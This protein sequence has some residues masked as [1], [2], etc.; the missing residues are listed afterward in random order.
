MEGLSK[1][2]QFLLKRLLEQVKGL[3]DLIT[4][5][6]S[7][8]QNVTQGADYQGEQDPSDEEA[9]MEPEE[10]ESAVEASIGA[11]ALRQITLIHNSI[12]KVE[13]RQMIANP[14]VQRLIKTAGEIEAQARSS[15]TLELPR[16]VS[17][18]IKAVER[19]TLR[20]SVF[21][22]LFFYLPLLFT[23]FYLP[24]SPFLFFSFLS[25]IFFHSVFFFFHLFHISFTLFSLL[26][27]NF[28]YHYSD[29]IY[30]FLFF[31]S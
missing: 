7:T 2:D 12:K 27:F 6:Q 30:I 21:L 10:L 11:K 9:E 26:F 28:I 4:E 13:A 1:E 29:C 16:P 15:I 19:S 18:A 25:P 31:R 20:F 3:R 14:N 22:L 5:A 8:P 17:R 23:P 24:L